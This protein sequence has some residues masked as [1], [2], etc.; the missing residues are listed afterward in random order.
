M[1][2]VFDEV[3]TR[4]ESPLQ[5]SEPQP[6]QGQGGEQPSPQSQL[7]CW[8]Y[9]QSIVQRRQQRLEAD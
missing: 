7:H 2:V 3:V 8:Q 4:V 5:P 6:Q 1:G 9:Q